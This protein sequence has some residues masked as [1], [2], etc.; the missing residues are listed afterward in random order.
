[1]DI[2]Q[3]VAAVLGPTLMIVTVSELLNLRIWRDVHPS[4]VY[5]NGLLFLIGGLIIVTTHNVWD[6]DLSLL[7]TLS[8]W[9]LV[10]AGSFR[11]FFPTAPQLG[12]GIVTY[13]LIAALFTLGACLTVYAFLNVFR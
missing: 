6:V 9:L 2:S 11:M 3:R 4:V 13:I 1:M 8:G 7:V 10:M 5:L 12:A